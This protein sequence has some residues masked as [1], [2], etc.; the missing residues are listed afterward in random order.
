VVVMVS[1]VVSRAGQYR[2]HQNRRATQPELIAT[3]S[4]R[5]RACDWGRQYRPARPGA[6]GAAPGARPRDEA[7]TA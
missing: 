1:S 2:A 3:G 5:P 4:G 7:T 6:R